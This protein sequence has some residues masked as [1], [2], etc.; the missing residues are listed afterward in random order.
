M[1]S[2]EKITAEK[3]SIINYYKSIFPVDL[4]KKKFMNIKILL[5]LKIN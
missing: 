4:C 3:P 1:N 2:L 5:I